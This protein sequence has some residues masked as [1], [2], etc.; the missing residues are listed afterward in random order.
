[1][2]SDTLVGMRLGEYEVIERIG[3]GGM[4]VVYRGMQPI[5]KKRVAIKVLKPHAAADEASV[6]RLVY[7]AEAVNSIRHRGI[8]DIFSLGRLP[9]GRPYIVMEYLEGEP[10][11]VYLASHPVPLSDAIALLSGICRPLGAAHRAG[12]VHRDLKP[13]NIFICESDGE[14]FLKLLDFGIAKKTGSDSEI[15]RVQR[16]LGTPNYMA[17][18]QALGKEITPRTDVYALGVIAFEMLTGRLPFGGKSVMDVIAGHV[19]APVPSLLAL[20]PSLP[21]G[22]DSVI[23]QMLDKRPEARPRSTDEVQQALLAHTSPMSSLKDGLQLKH[24]LG[25]LAS[26]EPGRLTVDATLLSPLKRATPGPRPKE[27]ALA[28]G[29]AVLV[30]A[31]ALAVGFTFLSSGAPAVPVP[32][33]LAPFDPARDAGPTAV[34]QPESLPVEAQQPP[35]AGL[36]AAPV[37]VDGGPR[38]A[39]VLR[40]VVTES[41]LAARIEKLE[42]MLG[43]ARADG[44]E[45]N[46]AAVKLLQ[47]YRLQ[48]TTRLAASE[49]EALWETLDDF[50][51]TFLR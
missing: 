32:D 1:M 39:R 25:E 29:L 18:E 20:N 41:A 31:L 34:V 51:R 16:V 35:D 19:S 14:R 30:V 6:Q 27:R 36:A 26:V 42:V 46:P 24:S 28:P 38:R 23:R 21:E 43:R 3:E 10:L 15:S 44:D 2:G 12:V 22:L 4:G 11:D 13:S 17:P 7:E 45:P 9:D 48:A 50:E 40:R 47:K 33:P 5:I 8:I 37:V 49:R